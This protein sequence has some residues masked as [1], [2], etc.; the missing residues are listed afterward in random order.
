MSKRCTTCHNVKELSSFKNGLA[1]CSA[2]LE[3]RKRKRERKR[4]EKRVKAEAKSRVQ[5][6]DSLPFAAIEKQHA[7]L[8]AHIDVPKRAHRC[9]T[10]KFDCVEQNQRRPL[11]LH[12]RSLLESS[13]ITTTSLRRELAVAKLTRGGTM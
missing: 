11:A 3:K 7:A 12:G 10:G 5:W 13:N 6:V 2:C 4:A 8:A 9:S 1:T